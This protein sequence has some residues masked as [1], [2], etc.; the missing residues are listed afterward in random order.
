MWFRIQGLRP[1]IHPI[2]PPGPI[3]RNPLKK[4]GDDAKGPRKL[5]CWTD[6]KVQRNPKP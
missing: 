2:K 1:L 5:P 6:T 4:V 3:L